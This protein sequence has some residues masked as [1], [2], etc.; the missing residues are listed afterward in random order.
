MLNVLSEVCSD[1]FLCCDDFPTF[2]EAPV[3]FEIVLLLCESHM[4]AQK[5]MMINKSPQ[6]QT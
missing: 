1:V 3:E 4:H 2:G 5:L 6:L